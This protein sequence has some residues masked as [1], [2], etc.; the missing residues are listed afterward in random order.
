MKEHR[1]V[2]TAAV[3][4][5][6]PVRFRANRR[7]GF[8]AGEL[9]AQAAGEN[10]L[11]A[12]NAIGAA[13]PVFQSSTS[14]SAGTGLVLRADWKQSAIHQPNFPDSNWG[15]ADAEA[16]LA[17]PLTRTAVPNFQ[18]LL[19]LSGLGQDKN[20]GIVDDNITTP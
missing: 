14:G 19:Q 3:R 11:I 13:N 20:A 8:G 10:G 17:E 15:K 9:L 12:G 7:P 16:H 1:P 18:C 6:R 4:S 5:R 2:K